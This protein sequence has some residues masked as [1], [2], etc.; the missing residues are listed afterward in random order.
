MLDSNA[1]ISVKF[2]FDS[3]N[4]KRIRPIDRNIH[5]FF[6]C[7]IHNTLL[8]NKN[9]FKCKWNVKRERESTLKNNGNSPVGV[10]LGTIAPIEHELIIL[11]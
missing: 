2:N 9:V 7:I 3:M 11:R 5:L 6:R 4:M 1:I 8:R 10:L